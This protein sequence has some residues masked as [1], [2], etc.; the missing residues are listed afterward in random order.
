MGRLQSGNK[1][2]NDSA[3]TQHGVSV[4]FSLV[5]AYVFSVILSAGYFGIQLD[6]C[7]NEK[8]HSEN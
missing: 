4:F 6:S 1:A 8:L 7:C 2:S 3:D 5:E